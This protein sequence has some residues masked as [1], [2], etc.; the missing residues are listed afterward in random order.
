MKTLKLAVKTCGDSAFV[1]KKGVNYGYAF[2]RLYTRFEE[3]VDKEF[4]DKLMSEFDMNAR[5][6]RYLS[7]DVKG[8]LDA[9]EVRREKL[10]ERIEDY[11]FVLNDEKSTGKQRFNAFRKIHELNDSLLRDCTWGGLDNI[12]RLSKECSKENR[13]E[14]TVLIIKDEIRQ[15]RFSGAY[16]VGA[17]SDNGNLNF[18]FS[19]LDKG[20]VIYKPNKG[21]K[22]EISFYGAYKYLKELTIL[23]EM[24][25]AGLISI[26][27]R[28]SSHH[29]YITFDE[30]ILNGY[31]VDVK[32]RKKEY[33]EIRELNLPDEELKD[34]I[35]QVTLKYYAE[36]R[37]RMLVDKI[38]NR[39]FAIDL[40]PKYIGWAI[41]DPDGNGGYIVIA[42]GIYDLSYL[43]KKLGKKSSSVAQKKQNNK[44]KTEIQKLIVK[45]FRKIKHY[46]CSVF[47]CEDLDFK[48]KDKVMSEL[49]REARRQ[50]NNVWN[51][52]L[53]MNGVT[54]Y[55][56]E[57]GVELRKVNSYLSSF[58]G[59][60][61]H[62]LV[63]PANAA[64]EIGRRGLYKYVKGSTILPPMTA[65]DFETLASIY[66]KMG[67]EERDLR[68]KIGSSWV[69]AY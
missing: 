27:V 17:A 3:S 63:D 48:T 46:K 25:L 43:S 69:L 44:R 30:E 39:V 10:R 22:I 55:C 66:S 57:R 12:R 13:N 4:I 36:Q 56:H 11:F 53:I 34:A 40:N 31:A 18:D 29:I 49:S 26:T 58:I 37:Q 7:I 65:R 1:D 20:L 28:V 33:A 59:N 45:M 60:I 24:A 32:A 52:T 16:Y 35:K 50:A 14:Q 47:A 54:K 51:R 2:L 67:Y 64:V 41:L 8:A 5:E 62:E 9:E 19:E 21:K 68:D 23:K 15:S 61:Q 6:Y 42:S 38:P